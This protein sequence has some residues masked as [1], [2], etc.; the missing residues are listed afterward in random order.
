MKNLKVKKKLWS[1][2]FVLIL[3]MMIPMAVNSI[4]LGRITDRYRTFVE[5]NYLAE[6]Y[7]YNIRLEMD[8]GVKNILLAAEA[9]TSA[10]ME[11]YLASAEESLNRVGEYIEW[12][13][14]SYEGDISKILEYD[15]VRLQAVDSRPEIFE[16]I[17]ENTPKGDAR[18]AQ[19]LADYNKALEQAGAKITEFAQQLSVN[20]KDMFTRSMGVKEGIVLFQKECF[21]VAIILSA[22]MVAVTTKALLKPI[23]EIDH[24]IDKMR[25]GD[26]S[27][28]VTYTSRDEL[29]HMAENMRAMLIS[30]REIVHDQMEMMMGMAEGNFAVKS[31]DESI[32]IGEF[33]I[34]YDAIQEIKKRLGETFVQVQQVARLVTA[35]SDQVSAGA[36]HLAH[37]AMQQASSIEQL[38]ATI[39]EITQ[40]IKDTA[41]FSEGSREDTLRIQKEAAKSNEDMQE[42][43]KAMGD[44]SENS[45]Q[46]SKIVKTIEDIA[47]QTNILSLNAAVE[48]AR[49]GVAGKGFAVVAD[50][51]RNLASKS[52]DASKSTAAL[53]ENSLSAVQRGREITDKTAESL[54]RVIADINK[55]AE[56]IT[57]IAQEAMT[58]ANSVGQISIGVDQISGV[59]Q[60]TS[61]TSQEGAASSE[62]LSSQAQ[63][64]KHLMSQ[65]RWDEDLIQL[66]EQEDNSAN[67][68]LPAHALSQPDSSK[69]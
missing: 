54:T 38:A 14:T 36:Q 15:E 67:E 12:F 42:L 21:V 9:S 19:L 22:I 45:A 2:F 53:I 57:H 35:G 64:L 61:A 11:N 13:K 48:A 18:A 26:F 59:V 31:K 49:A 47:F 55:V 5:Q 66:E 20:S 4:G 29:G 32:Y 68:A 23:Q 25:S 33:K 52:A 10:D 60:T 56:S 16:A 27:A 44:I 3:L 24:A 6:I 34:L 63:V 69:Y 51:V 30:L 58:Q 37:G 7:V 65:F 28:E 39:T 8:T 1:M 62:E 46:I 50:E 40:Q 41:E 17:R 43:L